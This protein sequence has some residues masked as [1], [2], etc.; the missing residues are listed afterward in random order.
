MTTYL[1]NPIFGRLAGAYLRTEGGRIEK[2]LPES[3]WYQLLWTYYLNNG[4]YDYLRQMGHY[5]SNHFLRSIYNPAA[6]TVDFYPAVVWPGS[7]PRAIPLVDVEGAENVDRIHPHIMKLWRWSNWGQ[8]KQVLARCL[9]VTGEQYLK[10]STPAGKER[11]YIKRIPPQFV[12]DR[13]FDERGYLAYCRIDLPVTVRNAQEETREM[14][15]TEIWDRERV[16][17]WKAHEHGPRARITQLGRPDEETELSTWG[18]DFVPIAHIAQIDLGDHTGLGSFAGAVDKIDNVN[19]TATQLHR[20]AFRHNRVTWA[21][22]ANAM[23]PTGRPL[24]PPVIKDRTTGQASD[25]LEL[26]DEEILRLPGTSDIVPLVPNLQYSDM[27]AII[28]ADMAEIERDLPETQY[29]RLKEAPELSGVAIRLM[30]APAVARAHE[31][32]G[33]LETALIRVHQMALTIGKNIGAWKAAGLKDPGEFTKGDFDHEFAERPVIN[34]GRH[35]RAD[36]AIKETGAGIPLATS[37]RWSGMTEDELAQMAEDKEAETTQQN[38]ALASAM[39][40]SMA[41]FSN[42]GQSNGLEQVGF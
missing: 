27:L 28:E 20:M 31:V 6:R 4:L 38:S 8:E 1:P 18:I 35:E 2:E 22:R 30:L 3:T 24:P 41:S 33:N 9:A 11:V 13:D 37:L 34:T 36:L 32:R 5:T 17:I 42:G 16:R 29:F 7:L 19:I 15:Y 25:T 23:D 39:V 21:L 40:N 14:T 26:G 12:T 10:V